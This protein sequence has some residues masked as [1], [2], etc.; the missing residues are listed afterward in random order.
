[1]CKLFAE[2]KYSKKCCSNGIT[3]WSFEN[4]Q[5][6]PLSSFEILQDH[7]LVLATRALETCRPVLFNMGEIAT[8]GDLIRQGGDFV[9]YQFWGE[10]SAYKGAIS[11]D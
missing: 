2:Q 8:S 10:L 9:I 6:H 11:V 5:E 1:M 7:S 4:L 3:L